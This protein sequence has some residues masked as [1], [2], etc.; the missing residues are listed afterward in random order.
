MQLWFTEE[1]TS[2]LRFSCKIYK[3]LHR[4]KSQYQ[5]IS[6]IETHQFGKMLVIDG[7]VQTTEGDEFVYHEMLVHVPMFTHDNP[8][9]VLVIGGGDGGSIK[10]ILKHPN[11]KKVVLVEIDER[12]VQI[13]K[14]YLPEISYGINDPKVD[15]VFADGIQYVKKTKNEFDVILIDSTDPVGPAVGLFSKEF[16]SAVFECLK[17]DGIMCAQTES[18]FLNSSLISKIYKDIYSIFPITK[19]FLAS[20]PTYPS[21]LWS[22][23]IGSKKYNPLEITWENKHDIKTKYY[24]KALHQAAFVLPAFVEKLLAGGRS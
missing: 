13:S 16:Y 5:D 6:V 4:E 21:G 18:P 17:Q 9:K 22:F 15:V 19:L 11:V 20:I 8:E 12:V 1:Q 7:T 10:E 24:S 3:T 2:N 14:K 23:T